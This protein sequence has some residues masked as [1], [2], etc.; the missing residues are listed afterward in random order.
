MTERPTTCPNGHPIEWFEPKTEAFH[1]AFGMCACDV[2]QSSYTAGDFDVWPEEQALIDAIHT[3]RQ[4]LQSFV[5]HHEA[6]AKDHATEI[7]AERAAREKAEVRVAFLKVVITDLAYLPDPLGGDA[8]CCEC[9]APALDPHEPDCKIGQALTADPSPL[10]A[11]VEAAREY[12]TAFDKLDGPRE[13][14][15]KLKALRSALSQLDGGNK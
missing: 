2:F 11:V 12:I 9:D 1:G 6:E 5:K 13:P 4:A 10:L 14:H 8:T 7:A 15:L 3:E